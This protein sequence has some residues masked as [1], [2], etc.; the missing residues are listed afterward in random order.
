MTTPPMSGYP[1]AV[2]RVTCG[3]DRHAIRW[4]AGELL[5]S[6]HGDPEGE[7]ALAV[8][9]GTSYACVEVLDTWARRRDDPRLL[10]ALTRG[11]ADPV[12]PGPDSPGMRLR[13]RGPGNSLAGLRFA[14]AGRRGVGWASS[15]PSVMLGRTQSA[16]LGAADQAGSFEEDLARLAGL[17]RNL[18]VRLV[19]TV[20]SR[21]L[22]RITAGD[23]EG[24][25]VRP[26]L[27]ASLFGRASNAIR[28]W[29]G[30]PSLD[31]AVDVVNLG[32]EEISSAGDG[33]AM[34]LA[35]PLEWV[36]E[37]WGRDLAVIGGRFALALIEAAEGRT[38]LRTVGSDLGPARSLT[39]ELA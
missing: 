32:E 19:A 13:Q 21:L 6:D 17:G 4:D 37:V 33:N 38:T 1:P 12:A 10:S 15:A 11:F 3:D 18:A 20:T 7:R 28:T 14:T 30:D 25:L 22:E 8:L 31:V 5:A 26:A 27:E 24:A 39:I 9:G 35:L 2:A 29:S 34:R 36:S 16:F 23:P